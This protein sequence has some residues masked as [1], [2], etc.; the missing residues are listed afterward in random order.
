MRVDR[1]ALQGAP[2][3]CAGADSCRIVSVEAAR[4]SPRARVPP[5]VCNP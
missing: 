4:D 2:G 5:T 1:G 3:S